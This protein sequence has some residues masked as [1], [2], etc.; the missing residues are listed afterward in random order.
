MT[1]MLFKSSLMVTSFMSSKSGTKLRRRSQQVRRK[2]KSKK[3]LQPRKLSVM[4]PSVEVMQ[5]LLKRRRR[6]MKKLRKSL[7]PN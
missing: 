4:I 5:N 2:R 3:Q 6:R 7:N 1:I